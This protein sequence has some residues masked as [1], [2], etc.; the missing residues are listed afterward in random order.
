[1]EGVSKLPQDPWSP[2]RLSSAIATLAELQ[3]LRFSKALALGDPLLWQL[4]K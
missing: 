3:T 1:M 4:A 2:P